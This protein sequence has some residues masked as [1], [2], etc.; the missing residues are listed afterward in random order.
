MAAVGDVLVHCATDERLTVVAHTATELVLE[1]VWPP[2]HVVPAHCHPKLAEEWRVLV[3]TVAIVVAGV[4]HILREGET[5]RAG[6]NIVHGAR[7][8]GGT[9]AHVRM[10]LSPPGQWLEVVERL[11]RGEDIGALLRTY[12]DELAA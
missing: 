6:A 8:L 9:P 10:V 1:D 12:P 11:F 2:G 7:N 5:A 3:G 4:E